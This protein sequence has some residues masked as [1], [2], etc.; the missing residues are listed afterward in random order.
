MDISVIILNYKSEQHLAN[1]V[2]SLQKYLS[3]I[4]HE[5]IIVN[6]DPILITRVLPNEHLQIL[7]NPSNEGFAKACNKGA[8]LAQGDLLFFL[9]PDTEIISGKIIDLI[10]AFQDPSVGIVSPQLITTDGTI[11]PWSAGYKI[12]LLEIILNNLGVVRSKKFWSTNN[13]SEPD[14][15]SGAALIIKSTLFKKLNGFDEHFF[16]YFEDVD[17]CKRVRE[18]LL[19]VVI[20]PTIKILHLSGQSSSSSNQQKKYYY[21]S[22]DYYFKKHF[23]SFSLFFLSSLRGLFLFFK[24]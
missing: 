20:M 18:Q 7:N 16:M 22:Q 12:N 19:H 9:N 11:Q 1:C 23:G 21:A 4:S 24:R 14:W 3:A 2:Q 5:I 13:L 15:T 6:N 10:T 17:L 8:T